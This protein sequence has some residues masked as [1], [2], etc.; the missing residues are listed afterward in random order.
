MPR[1]FSSTVAHPALHLSGPLEGSG[2]SPGDAAPA[3]QAKQE[4]EGGCHPPNG[5]QPPR[6]PAAH[7][8]GPCPGSTV[9]WCCRTFSTAHICDGCGARHCIDC[10]QVG[11]RPSWQR[12]QPDVPGHLGTLDVP[13]APAPPGC[14][15][16]PPP[17]PP[18]WAQP[19]PAALFHLGSCPLGAGLAGAYR[20][21]SPKFTC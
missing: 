19:V 7:R 3:P 12:L 10:G 15:S 11:S 21:V 20:P 13:E 9:L 17:R 18:H 14:G 16:V 1:W 4:A 5:G 8:P 6:A 2:P